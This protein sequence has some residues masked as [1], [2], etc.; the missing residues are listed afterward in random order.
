MTEAA[1]KI[2][3]ADRAYDRFELTPIAGALGAE[4]VGVDVNNLDEETFDDL[5]AAWLLDQ[6]LAIRGQKL[7]PEQ[8]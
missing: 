4:V 2:S 3:F 7:T 5:Y 1:G 6:V 8:Q